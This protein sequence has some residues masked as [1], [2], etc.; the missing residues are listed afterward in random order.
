[1]LKQ[2]QHFISLKVFPWHVL[3]TGQPWKNSTNMYLC[4]YYINKKPRH[5]FK[6]FASVNSLCVQKTPRCSYYYCAYFTNEES[7]VQADFDILIWF[8]FNVLDYLTH[9]VPVQVS[10]HGVLKIGSILRKKKKKKPKHSISR[11]QEN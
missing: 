7:E 11:H 9:C 3:Q 5:W 8:R 6:C 1:M 10:I 2:F 4:A